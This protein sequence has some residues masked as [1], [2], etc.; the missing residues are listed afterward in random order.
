[1]VGAGHSKS[2]EATDLGLEAEPLLGAGP[3]SESLE[4][5]D[6]GLEAEPLL[7]ETHSRNFRG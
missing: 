6:L 5:T 2:A 4:E 1:M 3:I 7:G